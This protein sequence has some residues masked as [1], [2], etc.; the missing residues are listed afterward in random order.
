[1]YRNSSKKNTLQNNKNNQAEDS[2]RLLQAILDSANYSII[3]TNVDGVICAFNAAAE[4]MLGYSA[5]EMIGKL[6][7]TTFHD[8]EEI[9][10]RAIALT[11]E[12]G[13]PIDAGFE[14]FVAK[15]K[16]GQIE[17]TEWT[18]IHK[19]GSRFPVMLSITALRNKENQITGF[20]GIGYELTKRKQSQIELHNTLRELEFQ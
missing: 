18:Y 13:K 12:F 4:R 9:Q 17:E 3:A 20:L 19:D 7:P 16:L 15:A 8:F 14:V 6:T 2:L 1:M 10:Q 11:E 5:S